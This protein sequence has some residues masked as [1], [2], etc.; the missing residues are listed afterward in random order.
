MAL[1]Q[2]GENTPC[3]PFRTEQTEFGPQPV[4][5]TSGLD[6]AGMFCDYQAHQVTHD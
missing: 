3:C 4:R 5:H 2:G 6:P 1:A